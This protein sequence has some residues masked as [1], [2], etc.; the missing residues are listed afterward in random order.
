MGDNGL[1]LHRVKG[2]PIAFALST[3]SYKAILCLKMDEKS[4]RQPLGRRQWIIVH[5]LLQR[6]FLW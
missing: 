1:S 4:L 3:S 6:T 2:A 5:K